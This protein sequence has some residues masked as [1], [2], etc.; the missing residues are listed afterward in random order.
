MIEVTVKEYLDTVFGE[1]GIPV[2]METPKDL[3]DKFII[4]ELIDRGK[5]NHI[6]EATIE[7]R[8]YAE[9]KYE[10]AVLDE[11]L[12]EALEAFNEG[13]DITCHLGGGNDSTDTILKKYR[14]RCYFNFFNF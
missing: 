4:L 3:P 13:S 14:Y 7:F 2:L 12:R 10:A 1:E 11:R 6:N 9:S 5:E 8:C